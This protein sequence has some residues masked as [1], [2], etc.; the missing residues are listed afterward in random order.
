MEPSRAPWE[1][2]RGLRH[3]KFHGAIIRN[4]EHTG[5]YAARCTPEANTAAPYLPVDGF[6]KS[7]PLLLCRWIWLSMGRQDIPAQ[8]G[9]R[10]HTRSGMRET[11]TPARFCKN[12]V[13]RKGSPHR[14]GTMR[15][16]LVETTKTK[17]IRIC[18]IPARALGPPRDR[19]ETAAK[20]PIHRRTVFGRR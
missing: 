13:G 2:G 18:V 19:S 9:H 3:G 4:L 10:G 16:W 5:L 15:S 11:P 6:A 1:R 8:R 14:H 7:L 12:P 17:T 20:D